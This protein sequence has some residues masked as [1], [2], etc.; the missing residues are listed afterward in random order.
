[1]DINTLVTHKKKTHLGIGCIAKV[2][3]NN[4]F[5]VNFGTDG[6][7]PLTCTFDL[8]VEVDTSKCKT[9][10]F[11]TFKTRILSDKSELNHAILGNELKHYVG[12]GWITIGV[13]TKED[14]KLYKRVV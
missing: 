4:K 2:L 14:L 13:V 10:P 7:P 6:E 3:K 1:M 5:E 8:L 11:K 12:I 9:V